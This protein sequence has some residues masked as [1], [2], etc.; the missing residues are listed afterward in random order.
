MAR[1]LDGGQLHPEA[2]AE[3]RDFV[4]AA[5]F[6]GL[7]FAFDAAVAESSRNNNAIVAVKLPEVFGVAFIAFGRQPG[8]FRFAVKEPSRV[9]DRFDHGNVGIHQ[10]EFARFEVFAHD[11]D[12]DGFGRGMDGVDEFLPVGQIPLPGLKVELGKDAFAQMFGGKVQRH[13]VDRAGVGRRDDIA[14]VNV[15]KNGNFALARFI[16]REF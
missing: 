12:V 6:D 14:G 3:E 16:H 11:A 10:R 9:F 8:D 15:A 7:D 2:Q 13:F 1:E 4:D 5:V